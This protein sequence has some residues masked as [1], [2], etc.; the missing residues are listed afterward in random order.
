M[1]ISIPSHH[2]GM[3]YTT[4][5][6]TDVDLSRSFPG[7]C[8]FLIPSQKPSTMSMT[9]AVMNNSNVLGIVSNTIVRTFR[10]PLDDLI[11]DELPYW[12]KT[13]F[14]ALKTIRSNTGL[15]RLY[16]L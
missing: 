7:F 9:I 4:I 5:V 6:V 12:N 2:V 8:A 16:R 10:L 15:F 13:A 1:I 14:H 3:P 11:I